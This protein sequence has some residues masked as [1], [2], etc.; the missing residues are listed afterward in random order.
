MTIN[1]IVTAACLSLFAAS[2]HANTS[3]SKL[4]DLSNEIAA[5]NLSLPINVAMDTDCKQSLH[6]FPKLRESNI[7]FAVNKDTVESYPAWPLICSYVAVSDE[8][9]VRDLGK[10]DREIVFK[11]KTEQQPFLTIVLQQITDDEQDGYDYQLTT[12]NNQ[13]AM[14]YEHQ[15]LVMNLMLKNYHHVVGL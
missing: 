4:T 7:M 2:I 13:Y 11:R 6:K 10:G 3:V 5:E 8:V 14:K 1:A 12:M 15:K 9:D